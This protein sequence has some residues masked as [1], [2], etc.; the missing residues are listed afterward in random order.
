LVLL[1]DEGSLQH[2]LTDPKTK[3][4][5][6]YWVQVEGMPDD[7]AIEKLQWGVELKDGPT[8]PARVKRIAAPNVWPRNPPIRYRAK[9]PTSW[10][11]IQLRE[12]RNRQIRR[13]T[14]AVGFPTLRLIR[15]GIGRWRL[16]KLQ[17]GQWRKLNTRQRQQSRQ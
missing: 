5:K 1:T 13:M 3:T 9:I 8:L 2:R 10:L 4:W 12:G 14:A 16:G 11:E 15:E 7:T 6:S 17:P